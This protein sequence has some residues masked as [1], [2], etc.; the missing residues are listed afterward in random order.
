[1]VNYLQVFLNK[2]RN[3]YEY[4]NIGT[5]NDVLVL[6]IIESFERATGEKVPHKI[7]TRC[8]GDIEQIY[9]DIS[10]ANEELGGSAQS[11]LDKAL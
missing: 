11:L 6:E 2:K 3:N 5:G 1:M 7:V 10:Y 8:A 9:A 4:F